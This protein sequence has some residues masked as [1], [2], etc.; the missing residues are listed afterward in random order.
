MTTTSQSAGPPI[1][2]IVDNI[3]QNLPMPPPAN[4]FAALPGE[5]QSLIFHHLH[6]DYT[7]LT[8]LCLTSR[9]LLS[10]ARG[11]IYD[12]APLATTS[13]SDGTLLQLLKYI[14]RV[15]RKWRSGNT[16]TTDPLIWR[17]MSFA[18]Q[19]RNL[20][21]DRQDIDY[22]TNIAP[23]QATMALFRRT[24]NSF[25]ALSASQ[26]IIWAN[27]IALGYDYAL[28]RMLLSLLGRLHTL[29]LHGLQGSLPR[30]NHGLQAVSGLS[31]LRVL[32]L[33]AIKD[34]QLPTSC[35]Y[36]MA[37]PTSNELEISDMILTSQSVPSM[38]TMQISAKSLRFAQC[39]I[40]LNLLVAILSACQG[41]EIFEYSLSLGK[42][43][44]AYQSFH[45]GLHC[46]QDGLHQHRS[47]IKNL[48]LTFPGS[49][50]GNDRFFIGP[51]EGYTVLETLSVFQQHLGPGQASQ[52]KLISNLEK[53]PICLP[54]NSEAALLPA[55]HHDPSSHTRCQYE[56]SRY[57]LAQAQSLQNQL[58]S[59]LLE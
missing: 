39:Y 40:A 46:L 34:S 19:F 21:I 44:E 51:I 16:A 49:G 42:M 6:D 30:V 35:C 18:S 56:R 53:L 57:R 10:V 28:L 24:I 13:V 12:S 23:H 14:F 50:S 1:L 15:G 22:S 2:M 55:R 29:E 20:K 52:Q 7:A 5:I 9:A 38:T 25:T 37:L 4:H 59:S 3:A 54:G 43:L 17:V 11:V 36:L 31:T 26:K 32:K 47:T 27:D 33:Y 45:L 48:K 58:S 41:L 8:A